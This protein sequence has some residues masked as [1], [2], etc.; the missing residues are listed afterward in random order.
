M[1]KKFW[2]AFLDDGHGMNTPGKRTPAFPDGSFMHENEF[3][4]EVV[5]LLGK[6]LERSGFTVVYTAPTDEDTPL[7]ERT[8]LANRIYREHL[9]QYGKENVVAVF[10]SIHANAFKGVWGEWNGIETYYWGSNGKFSKEGK[11]LAEA[12]HRNLMLGTPFRDRGI[13]EG[14]FHVLRETTMPA[15]LAECGFMDNLREA[16]LLRSQQYREECATEIAR[17]I[18][19]YTNK[20]FIGEEEKETTNFKTLYEACNSKIRGLEEENR[21]LKERLKRISEITKQ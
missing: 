21:N 14:N 6:H 17:G 13:K 12:I 1:D 11:L 15:A 3:N 9:D 19:Q 8:A 7:G 4:R 18:C 10:V 16:Y 2:I 20:P 5:A